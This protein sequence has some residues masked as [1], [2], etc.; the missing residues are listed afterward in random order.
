MSVE[1]LNI[2]NANACVNVQETQENAKARLGS[3]VA[4]VFGTITQ[5]VEKERS[6]QALAKLDD[7]MLDDIGLSRADVADEIE[8]PFWVK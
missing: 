1:T 3:I 5:W 6:R 4:S 8:K 7:R 2:L